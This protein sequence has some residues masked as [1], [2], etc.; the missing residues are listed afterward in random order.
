VLEDVSVP[1]AVESVVA[2]VVSAVE[3]VPLGPSKALFNAS[4]YTDCVY[5]T[6][7]K[8]TIATITPAIAM[9]RPLFVLFLPVATTPAIPRASATIAMTAATLLINGIH[10]STMATIATTRPAMAMPEVD[11]FAG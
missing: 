1:V 7:A 2:A 11:F 9:P 6:T 4:T 10:E 5:K 8:D 3:T